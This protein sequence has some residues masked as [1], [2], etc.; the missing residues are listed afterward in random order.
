MNN[1]SKKDERRVLLD[2][3]FERAVENVVDAF[4]REGFVIKPLDG[5]DLRRPTVPG[6][7][8]RYAQL[9]ASLPGFG[10]RLPNGRLSRSSFLACRL[11]LFELTKCCTLLTAENPLAQYPAL[12]ALLPRVTT[13]I[14][15]ALRVVSGDPRRV[16]AA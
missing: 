8:L 16:Y 5:G 10:F 15:H 13:Q 12:Q 9:E 2:Q 3:R 1:P 7:P 4:L 11:S 6:E 14:E